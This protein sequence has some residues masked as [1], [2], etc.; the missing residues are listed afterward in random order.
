MWSKRALLQKGAAN[1]LD[2]WCT[3]RARLMYTRFL[4][5]QVASGGK[6]ELPRSC[7]EP[8]ET[9]GRRWTR[10]ILRSSDI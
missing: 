7:E 8:G 3:D 9:T 4:V 1:D 2:L 5:W 6:S 10:G